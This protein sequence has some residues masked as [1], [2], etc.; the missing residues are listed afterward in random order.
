MGSGEEQGTKDGADDEGEPG[1]Q[2]KRDV[3]DPEGLKLI[4]PVTSEEGQVI[5]SKDDQMTQTT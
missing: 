3:E 4:N 1:F 5:S 2:V